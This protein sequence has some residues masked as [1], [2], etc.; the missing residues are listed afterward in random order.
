[1]LDSIENIEQLIASRTS[2]L[3][4]PLEIYYAI[5]ERLEQMNGDKYSSRANF[6]R[7]QCENFSA[8]EKFDK[9]RQEWGV[10]NFDEDIVSV[11]DF[12]RGF[13]YTFRDHTTSWSD[14]QKAKEWFLT[15]IEGR[16]IRR[17]ELWS[18]DNG[19]DE[20]IETR[21]G[22]YKEILLSL[23]KDCDYEVLTSPV[24]SK[25][26]L[27]EYIKSFKQQAGDYTIE[28]IIED[29]IERNIN[30]TD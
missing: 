6:I 24:F 13:F 3:S 19:I 17:Y 4:E 18:C 20:C 1:M 12:K 16:F 25:S 10:D 28:E 27:N 26:E 15:S 2:E 7:Q 22:S 5:T 21:E 8:K 11:N 30:Y 29:Y 9:Y 23:L 14:N